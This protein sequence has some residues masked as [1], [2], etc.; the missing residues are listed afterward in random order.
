MALLTVCT[1][2][3]PEL[4]AA[5]ARAC[6]TN[7]S[8]KDFGEKFMR[9]SRGDQQR[10]MFA[11]LQ[12]Q[13]FSSENTDGP[14]YYGGYFAKRGFDRI[15][16][17]TDQFFGFSLE[18][19]NDWGTFSK[20]AGFYSMSRGEQVIH[21]LIERKSKCLKVLAISIVNIDEILSRKAEYT[22]FFEYA[23]F[24]PKLKNKIRY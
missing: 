16:L 9:M 13:R 12:F 4:A 2:V 14:S 11:D 10:H 15:A 3:S 6:D 8:F 18:Q 19:R 5:G 24:L 17:P 1:L 22:M 21:L 20:N 7:Q 23:E